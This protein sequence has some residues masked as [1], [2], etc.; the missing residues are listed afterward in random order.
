MSAISSESF[1]NYMRDTAAVWEMLAFVKLRSV[2]GDL[3][4]GALVE[5]ETRRI[6]HTK[7]GLIDPGTLRD[8]TARVR[9]ALQTQRSHNRRNSEIDIKYG[10]GGMLDIYFAMRYLQ[11]RDNVPDEGTDRSTAYMLKRLADGG[12]LTADDYRDILSGYEFLSELDHALRLTV[13]R[14]TQL[15]T[16]NQTVL[17]TIAQRMDLDSTSELLGQL[18][19]NRLA[20][21]SAFDNIVGQ[22]TSD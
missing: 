15:S 2:G 14:T 16:A 22:Q 13:G 12:S 9:H 10:S 5:T 6:I 8:E 1:L 4:L 21:R 19:L 3:T 20:V 11:L 17:A 18:T 7:A